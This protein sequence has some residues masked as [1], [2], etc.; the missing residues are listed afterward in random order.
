MNLI[1][2]QLEKRLKQSLNPNPDPFISDEEL[3]SNAKVEHTYDK[4]SN[5][6]V[7]LGILQEC[8][9]IKNKELIRTTN[10]NLLDEEPR[11][12]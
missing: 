1:A 10:L 6:K 5:I 2:Y 12:R 9:E 4:Q 11:C 7:T 3:D 8:T